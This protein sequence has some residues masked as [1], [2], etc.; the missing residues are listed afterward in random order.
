MGIRQ[1]KEEPIWPSQE[2]KTFILKEEC[3]K[4]NLNTVRYKI[5][6]KSL[7]SINIYQTTLDKI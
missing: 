6:Y 3:G 7:L 2:K 5:F 4:K 1:W